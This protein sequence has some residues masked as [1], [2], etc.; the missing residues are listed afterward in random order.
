MKEMRRQRIAMVQT[1]DQYM[2]CHRIVANHI[3]LKKSVTFRDEDPKLFASDPA[4]LGKKSDPTLDP[5]LI[6]NGEKIYLYFREVGIYSGSGRPKINGPDRIRILIPGY[7]IEI[8]HF[9]PG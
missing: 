3:F 6:R 2:L 9:S 7:I 5:T 4:Q 8:L 1:V